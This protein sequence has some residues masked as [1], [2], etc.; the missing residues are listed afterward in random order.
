[1]RRREFGGGEDG[2]GKLGHRVDEGDDFRSRQRGGVQV[3]REEQYLERGAQP[4]EL[5]LP[6][7]LMI[8]RFHPGGTV[9]RSPSRYP[10]SHPLQALFH[11]QLLE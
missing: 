2:V 4:E 10:V 7:E 8:R 9:R 6:V 5:Q 1:M 11:L 3:L